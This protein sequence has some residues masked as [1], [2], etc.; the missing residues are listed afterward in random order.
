MAS[1]LD[2]YRDNSLKDPATKSYT[3]V[4][5]PYHPWPLRKAAFTGMY[6]LPTISQLLHKLNEDG[7]FYFSSDLLIS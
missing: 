1:N 5:A 6:A 2:F 4:F 7:E 3:Q